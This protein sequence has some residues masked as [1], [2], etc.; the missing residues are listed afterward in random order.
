MLASDLLYSIPA[1]YIVCFLALAMF[2]AMK[3]G[4]VLAKNKKSA[5]LAE[6][7]SAE[8]IIT[9]LYALLGFILAFTYNMSESRFEKRKAHIVEEANAIGTALLRCDLYEDSTRL[10]LRKNFYQYIQA[11]IHFY[12]AGRD[13][14]ELNKAIE[15]TDKIAGKIWATATVHAKKY[16]GNYIVANQSIPSINDMIDMVTTRNAGLEATVPP[17]IVMMLLI[18]CIGISLFTGYYFA[19]YRTDWLVVSGFIITICMVVYITLDLD[20]PR[21]GLINMNTTQTHIL[22]LK[23]N[24]SAEEIK[25]YQLATGVH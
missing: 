10:E 3:T 11:R 2:L 18:L 23:T 22:K 14:N 19:G 7:S 17:I 12:E 4:L 21:R 15:A 6:K 8:T 24:F 25:I 20:R 1:L 5:L 9:A 16:P 13:T